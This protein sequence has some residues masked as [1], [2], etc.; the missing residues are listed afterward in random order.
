MPSQTC[1]SFYTAFKQNMETLGL[2]APASLFAA[3]Q[4]ATSTAV[5]LIAAF[6]T[7]GPRATLGELVGAT[8]GL[9]ALCAVAALSAAFYIGAVIGSL[10]VAADSVGACADRP[11]W[12]HAA[13]SWT[14]RNRVTLPAPVYAVIRRHPE[15]VQPGAGARRY[16]SH[17]RLGMG[18]AA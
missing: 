11:S 3:Q 2:P 7:L 6:K 4:T 16:A 9:E 14:T 18:R 5:A 15:V 12:L 1:P 17:A 8:T 10:I 13:R